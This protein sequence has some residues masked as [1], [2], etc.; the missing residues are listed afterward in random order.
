M[1]PNFLVLRKSPGFKLGV[2]QGTID[3]HFEP[4]TIRWNQD[5]L[6]DLVFVFCNQLVGQTDRLRF[7]ISSLAV[8]DFDFHGCILSFP[9]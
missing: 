8:N 4:S 3:T 7:V 2:D 6:L 5:E 9:F 1:F